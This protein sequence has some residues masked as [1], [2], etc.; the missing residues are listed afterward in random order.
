MITCL[1]CM[2]IPTHLFNISIFNWFKLWDNS[3]NALTPVFLFT[4]FSVWLNTHW[5]TETF[6]KLVIKLHFPV[7]R[8]HEHNTTPT[9]CNYFSRERIIKKVLLGCESCARQRVCFWIYGYWTAPESQAR[10]EGVYLSF[11]RISFRLHKANFRCCRSNEH[12]LYEITSSFKA[13]PEM[14]VINSLEI[15][16][17]I[18]K[19]Q[20]KALWASLISS[21]PKTQ[22]TQ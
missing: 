22:Y 1:I 19:M 18:H 21:D 17:F 4:V 3:S 9:P 11:L 7:C 15:S 5:W 12:V 8:C 6:W 10:G 20:H 14:M 2:F 16:S 13:E